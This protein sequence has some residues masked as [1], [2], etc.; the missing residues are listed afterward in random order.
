MNIAVLSANLGNFDQPLEHM[1]QSVEAFYHTFTDEDFPPITGFNGRTQYRIPKTHGWQMVPG[2]KH[3]LWLD[4]SITMQSP[5]SLKWYL[6]QLGE[7]DIAFFAHPSRTT[8]E[9]EVEHIEAHLAADKPYITSR[10]KGGL[11]RQFLDKIQAEGYPDDSLYASTAF[12]YHDTEKVRAAL[13][14]WW[15]AGTRYLTCD[16]VQ[17][18]YILKLHRLNVVTLPGKVFQSE[19]AQAKGR[20]G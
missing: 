4:G 15:Y 2:Y 5:D 7:A 11:H 18:P 19:H 13:A 20:R 14:D 16:Q 12:I 17:L 10:Y 8:I 3:Y 9:Q 1:P 6:E